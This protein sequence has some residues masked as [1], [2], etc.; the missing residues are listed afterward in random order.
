MAWSG[1][2]GYSSSR[3]VCGA[4]ISS[5]TRCFWPAWCVSAWAG[6]KRVTGYKNAPIVVT[7]HRR[8]A[9]S[10]H[11]LAR[12]LNTPSKVALS[13]PSRGQGLGHRGAKGCLVAAPWDFELRWLVLAL[14]IALVHGLLY[15]LLVPPWS[16]YDEPAHFE[17]VALIARH[18]RLPRPDEVDVALRRELGLSLIHI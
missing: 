6:S 3:H 4:V 1:R 9:C 8:L 12:P 11:E 10:P 16:H 13:G 2:D 18:S 15:V 17:Y 14:V 5:A 7:M